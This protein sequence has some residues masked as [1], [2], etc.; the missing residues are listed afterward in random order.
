MKQ[1]TT[2]FGLAVEKN[3][4]KAWTIC[5]Y[6]AESELIICRQGYCLL[7]FLQLK[8]QVVAHNCMKKRGPKC[9][10]TLVGTERGEEHG[11]EVSVTW[12]AFHFMSGKE[13]G[14]A[15]VRKNWRK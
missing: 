8:L 5:L 10:V 13:H 1:R 12:K 7:L 9:L 2:H 15:V 11:E 6:N 4:V 14:R 3:S